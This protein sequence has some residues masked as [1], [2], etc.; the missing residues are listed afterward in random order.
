[1]AVTRYLLPNDCLRLFQNVGE[2]L[3]AGLA[4]LGHLRN[5]SRWELW[6]LA[7]LHDF[8]YLLD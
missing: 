6:A 1:M 8:D 2:A 7:L 5:A 3:L 4:L